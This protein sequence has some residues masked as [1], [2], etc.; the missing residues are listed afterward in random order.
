MDVLEFKDNYRFLSN[1]YAVLFYIDRKL[2]LSSEHWYQCN[3]TTDILVYETI[4]MCK[5]GY[6]AKRLGNSPDIIIRPDWEKIKLDIMYK[7][8]F[9]KFSQNNDIRRKLL[10]TGT[11]LLEEN[12]NHGDSFWGIYKG[13][14]ENHLGRILM[15]VRE[16]LNES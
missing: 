1:M 4:R 8:V 10:A 12:N 16:V 2:Y 6:D 14:G 11:G 3:K 13:V 7:G 9:N 5:N 15:K